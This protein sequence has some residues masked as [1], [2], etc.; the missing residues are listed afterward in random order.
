MLREGVQAAGDDLGIVAGGELGPGVLEDGGE[1]G[2]AQMLLRQVAE[3]E[4][5]G[6]LAVIDAEQDGAIVAARR[7]DDGAVD[8]PEPELAQVDVFLEV[9][10]VGGKY[11]LRKIA[12]EAVETRVELPGVFGRDRLA[13]VDQALQTDASRAEGRIDRP[14]GEVADGAGEVALVQWF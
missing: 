6:E 8:Q 7:V 14:Q 13:G 1:R 9:G 3:R 12:L 11:K 10:D 4:A 2:L 5:G